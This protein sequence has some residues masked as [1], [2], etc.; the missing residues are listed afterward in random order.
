MYLWL[1]VWLNIIRVVLLHLVLTQITK[2]DTIL[3]TFEPTP[4]L[5]GWS[6]WDDTTCG[7]LFR[8]M[9]F[10]N[11]VSY[12]T[13]IFYR[14]LLKTSLSMIKKY[15]RHHLISKPIIYQY[16]TVNRNR[17]S[18]TTQKTKGGCTHFQQPV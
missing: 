16:N 7:Y 11:N 15:I 17:L 5:F 3:I 12:T 10:K 13:M 14:I 4:F 2:Y 18:L 9:A 8:K 1:N 6:F